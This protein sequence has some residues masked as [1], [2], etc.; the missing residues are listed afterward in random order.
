MANTK[1]KV[2]II[3]VNDFLKEEITEN[4]SSN[5]ICLNGAHSIIFR[6][7]RPLLNSLVT[8]TIDDKSLLNTHEVNINPGELRTRDKIISKS[9]R[10]G[11]YRLIISHISFP[12]ESFDTI[13]MIARMKIVVN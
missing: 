9:A 1:R 11:D 7:E 10:R 8:I 13:E 5:K 2:L 4:C 12:F 3:D 6:K